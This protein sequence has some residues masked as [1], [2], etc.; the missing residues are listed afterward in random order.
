MPGLIGKKVGM[1]RIFDEAGVQIPV[2]VIE[3][4]PCPVV[5]VKSR[6]RDGYQAVQLGFGAQMAKRA[7]R[8]ETGHAAKAGLEKAPRLMREFDMS[9]GEQYEV[10]QQLTVSLFE[11][12]DLVKVTV[13]IERS[14]DTLW[15]P[16][17]A[18]RTFEGRR[19]VMVRVGDRL[20]KVDVKLGVEGQDR[21]EILEGLE[22][23]QIIEGL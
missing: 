7:S 5:D 17:A 21:I 10:G 23:G 19:F 6:E 20:Q 16:T 13:L 3:A 1:T 15:L 8:A 18:V 9:E 2:T 22:E 12:G 4:G 14:E 11:A